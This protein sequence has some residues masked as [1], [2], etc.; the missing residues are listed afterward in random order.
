[1]QFLGGLSLQKFR[2]Q[3]QY[4]LTDT[5]RKLS[6]NILSVEPAL[7]ELV[8]LVCGK[9]QIW[10]EHIQNSDYWYELLPGYLY[11]T[12]PACKHFELGTAANS[13]LERWA[14]LRSVFCDG[15][16]PQLKHLDKVILNLMENDIHQVLHTIQLM[17]DNQWF[18]THLTDLFYNS[19]QLQIMGDHQVEYVI[20]YFQTLNT[21][22][23]IISCHV[24]FLVIR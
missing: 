20:N 21:S 4:W 23:Y 16:E 18:V 15:C 13:W 12:N 5:E 3:W 24:E 17:A 8:Q 11:Y 7:E 10:D 22:F 14:S 6:T 9:T 19:D 1:M 2:S